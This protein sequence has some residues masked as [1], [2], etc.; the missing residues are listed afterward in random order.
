MT[1]LLIA[2]ALI[3]LTAWL[4]ARLYDWIRTDGLGHRA[5]PRSHRDWTEGADGYLR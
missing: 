2:L 1:T 4:G 5:P 3:T